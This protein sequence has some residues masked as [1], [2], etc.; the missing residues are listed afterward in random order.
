MLNFALTPLAPVNLTVGI[1]TGVTQS[2]LQVCYD[3]SISANESFSRALEFVTTY[4]VQP[5]TRAPLCRTPPFGRT[6]TKDTSLD[7]R[8][9][10]E[11]Y[12]QPQKATLCWRLARSQLIEVGKE[13]SV[14]SPLIT[15]WQP[16]EEET[17]AE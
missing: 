14:Q 9:H 12:H 10:L 1:L 16:R 8:E 15:L 17:L 6:L 13:I 4:Y 11:H 7:V 2:F 5:T 3:T